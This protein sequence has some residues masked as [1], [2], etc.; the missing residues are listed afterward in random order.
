VSVSGYQG[1]LADLLARYGAELQLA[2]GDDLWREGDPGDSV[3]LLLEGILEVIF[4]SPDGHVVVLRRL[5]PGAVLGEIACLDGR[6]RSAGIRAAT[7]ARITRCPAG[8]F[9]D[10]LHRRPDILEQLLLQ[11]V[12][13]VRRL[14]AQVTRSHHR[15]ITDPLTHLYNLGF[16]TE[17]LGLEMERAEKTGDPLSVVMFDIDHFKHFNDSHGHQAGNDA[18]VMV[19]QILKSSGRRGDIVARYGGEEF[20]VLLYGAGREEA[21]RFAEAV[22]RNIELT[23]FVGGG[24]QPLGRVT[25]SGGVACFPEDAGELNALIVVADGNLYRA[26]QQ[27]RNRVVVEQE[28]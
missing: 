10:L 17:R 25:L 3:V 28:H 16:F 20:V 2:A 14:T 12:E 19:A 8:R 27:G 9:R 6:P 26:K 23:D 11:Q 1:S 13:T 24:E 18:L 21:G 22:R 4:D 7:D 15:A 5:E